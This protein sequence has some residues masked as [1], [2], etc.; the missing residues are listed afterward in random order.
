MFA[1]EQVSP[2]SEQA[3]SIEGAWLFLHQASGFDSRQHLVEV[4]NAFGANCNAHLLRL[5]VG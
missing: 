1:G 5:G 3:V 2:L 4:G